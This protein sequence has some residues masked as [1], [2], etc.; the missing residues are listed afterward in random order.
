MIAENI[1][2]LQQKIKEVCEEV[3]RNPE[4]I[5]I[6]AV[7][8][9]FSS[10]LIIEAYNAG[11]VDFAENYAQ[12]FIEKKKELAHLPVQW[13]FIGH[14]QTNKVKYV[15]GQVELIHSV[16]S[17]KVAKEISDY[18]SKKNINQNVLLEVN[19]SGEQ[20]KYGFKPEEVIDAVSETMKL[21]NIKLVGLMTIGKFS[22]DPEESR[23]EFRLL[24][25]LRDEVRRKGFEINHLSMGM[26]NDFIVAIQEGAT[27]L[28]IGSAIF[29]PRLYNN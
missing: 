20:T 21:K 17:L 26:S 28:R 16:D 2:R 10:K 24:N 3:K 12:E 22:D 1:K 29:G 7:T 8:K 5:K 15:A 13:H 19:T 27:I 11:I 18:C 25:E 6:V 23:S 14:L 9:T 4:D